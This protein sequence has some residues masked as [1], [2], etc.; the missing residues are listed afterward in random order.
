MFQQ[1]YQFQTMRQ[2]GEEWRLIQHKRSEGL[3]REGIVA[4][5]YR[6]RDLNRANLLPQDPHR[7]LDPDQ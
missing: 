7:D 3:D 2:Q 6:L 1:A 5:C 4:E